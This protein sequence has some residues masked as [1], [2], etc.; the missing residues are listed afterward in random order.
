MDWIIE[1]LVLTT[2]L[3]VIVAILAVVAIFWVLPKIY[4]HETRPQFASATASLVIAVLFSVILNNWYAVRRDRD[5]R[6]RALRDQHLSQLRPVLRKEAEQ[7]RLVPTEIVKEGHLSK[8]ATVGIQADPQSLLW[9]DVMSQDLPQHFP[10]YDQSKR[11]L[12][13]QIT[14]QDQA[15]RNLLNLVRGQIKP[16][17]NLTPYWTEIAAMSFIVQCLGHGEGIKL[18]VSEGGFSFS[19]LGGS[20]AVSGS[21]NNPPRPSPDEV[22]AYR[23]FQSLHPDPVFMSYCERLKTGEDAIRAESENLVKRALLQSEMTVLSGTC[24]FV[25]SNSL[26]D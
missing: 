7:L 22:A 19:Y 21:E 26:S 6:L 23:A 5:N 1:H 3:T 15:F 12:L 17:R 8:V 14:E 9:P 2:L 24:E 16:D 18:R 13:N 20:Q 10:D 11:R 25:R 4:S